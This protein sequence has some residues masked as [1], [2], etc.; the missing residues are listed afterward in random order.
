M[1]A[2]EDPVL[3]IRAGVDDAAADEILLY[4][5]EN[6]TRDYGF[7]A[8]FHVILRHKT[9]VLTAPA[10]SVILYAATLL[11]PLTSMFTPARMNFCRH[12][13]FYVALW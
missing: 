3:P 9:V 2:T 8:V 10:V 13:D 1:T 6:F 5:H 7:V 4:L 12:G 11:M